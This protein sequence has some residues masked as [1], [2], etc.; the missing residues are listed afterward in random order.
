MSSLSSPMEERPGSPVSKE[1]EKDLDQQPEESSLSVDKGEDVTKPASLASYL[2]ILSYGTRNGGLV[3]MIV[4][5]ICAMGSG[6]ALPLMTIIFGRIVGDF[7]SYTAPGQS[8]NQQKFTSTINR[9]SLYIVYLFIGKF[10]LT[11]ISMICFR[12]IS[13]YASAALRLEY[14]HS[15]FSMPVSKLDEISVGTVS[16]AITAQSNTI[17]QSVSDR[18]A[19]L[20]Q[21]LALL[22]SAY[23]IAFRYSWAMTLV[24][25]SAILFVILCFCLTVPFMIKGQQYTDQADNKH[26]AIAADAFASIRTVFSLGAE[27]PL[28]RKH[29]QWIDE[30]CRRGLRMS[31]MTGIHLAA[32]FFAMYVSFALAFWF[33]LKLY[34]DGNIA[35]IN[36]V[37]TVFFSVLLVVTIMGGIAAPLMAISKAV[38]ASGA[39]FGVIDSERA[40]TAGLRE[41]EATS[42]AD[43]VFE[44]VTFAYP[45]RAE[46]QVLKDLSVRLPRS[47]TTALVGPSGS[48]KSTIVALVERW[49]Q[50]QGP[51][52]LEKETT[53]GRILVGEH[54]INDLDVKWWRSQVGLVQ[55]EPFLFNESIFHNVAF[56]LIGSK[57][58]NESEAVKLEMVIE[59]CKESYADEFV[60]RLPERY[61]TRV[62]E[63]G[64]NLSG[65][66]RQ[67]LAIARSIVG[68]PSILI[69]DE[70]TSAIDV[71]GEKIVQAAL[72][73]VSKDRTTIMIAHRLSTVRRADNIVV[74]QNGTCAEQGS[75]RELMLH[76]GVYRDL[77]NAQQLEPLVGSE[78]PAAVDTVI[79]QKEELLHP[80]EYP[81]DEKEEGSVKETKTK[82]RG[83]MRSVS[84]ILS[85]HRKYWLLFVVVIIS[86]IGGGSGYALQS[87]L[88][89]KLIQVFQFKGQKLVDG[90]NFWALM[91]FILALAMAAFY[92]VLGTATNTISMRVGTTYRKEYFANILKRPV[93]FFDRDENSSGTLIS[94]LSLDPKQVQ[95][96]LGPM[97]VFPLISVFN[98][99]GCVIISFVFGWKLA[100]VTFFGAMPFILLAAF[101]RIRHETH[102][103]SMNAAVYADSSKFATE[104]IRAFRTVT[105][106]TM[107]D[108]IIQRY[109]N[110]LREQ[111]AKAFRKSWYAT[112]VFAF[113]DSV[114]LCA[115]ALTFWY[116]G[117]LLGSHEYGGTAFF[118]VYIA[119][120]QGGQAAG[121][122]LS[123]GPNVAQARSSANRILASRKPV[124]GQL[125]DPAAEP[126]PPDLRPSVELRDVS[127]SYPGRDVLTFDKLNVSIES[128]QFI[129]FV[130]PSGCGKSTTI[131]LLERFYDPTEG[132]ILFGGRDIT[133]IQRTSYRRSLSLVAQEPKL[134]EGTIRD[135]LLLGIEGTQGA[136][137]EE[138]LIQAC[139]DAEI[140]DFITSLPDGYLTELGV[141]AQA[142]L[143]GGQKQRL[144]IARALLRNP[145][146]LLLDEATSSLD[147]QSEKL[148]QQA[149]ERLAGT[150]SMTIIAVAHR[151]ATIQKADVIFVFG[152]GA[153]G[154]GSTILEQGSHHELLRNKG[155]Y[156]QMCQAQALDR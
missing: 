105:A 48:G 49:Y 86:A 103:E 23:A 134:F 136:Q 70:A 72:D 151:L 81:A 123:F 65:G 102:F 51:T 58:E 13:L 107:E 100:A 36:T 25:S 30:A 99:T 128:G 111:R 144:C 106:L 42:Q 62:G 156:W 142:S 21:S 145:R 89:A 39:F 1:K 17:Q 44:N 7:N 8:S 112:L 84:I 28:S 109:S 124:E 57:W 26:A 155:A 6:I 34:R 125:E 22:I 88:F 31:V 61:S 135:N 67:R 77:V 10:V 19:I 64:I 55:Q 130:G 24:V 92:F 69:L 80:E 131:S 143:S 147:S 97:G 20:F 113:S 138:R 76:G 47:K 79:S 27:G 150:K 93:S 133:T 140:H 139:K 149:M 91:F 141:N 114:E 66:Q 60:E 122:F 11:Y 53:S 52:D 68:Q 35:N 132:Q 29:S 95:D 154:R 83:F 63:G 33:G 15:L 12:I 146:L 32:L 3:A 119:I 87:W 115:M 38:S 50:L 14:T 117:Q 75:H 129:A 153:P 90:A 152:E 148:V 2:R 37:I 73:R 126:M 94:R 71:R 108:T 82:S 118:V 137:S 56:G 46:T 4:G 54:D 16:N 43:I 104:A 116:G 18:L 85:E 127:F 78:E 101:M 5:L 41:P 45:T 96:L 120:I 9:N 121:Q 74:M 40:P 98:V 59:A 110:L